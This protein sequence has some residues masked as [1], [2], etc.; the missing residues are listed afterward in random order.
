MTPADG[1]S[2]A[3]NA[4]GAWKKP[5]TAMPAPETSTDRSHDGIRRLVIDIPKIGQ[6]AVLMGNTGPARTAPDYFPTLVANDVLGGGYSARLNEEIR[7]KRG[8]SYG[9]SSRI[10]SRKNAAPIIAAAQTRNDAVPQVVK[11]M[12]GEMAKL[13]AVAH[14]GREMD[15]RKATLI[16]SFGRSVE[17]T[18]GLAGQLSELA[19]FN[20]PL[21][22]LRTYTSDI[23]AV[24]PEAAEAAA[25]AH[26]SPDAA[27]LVVVGDSKVFGKDLAK[28]YPKLETIEI[29]KLNLDS[30]T[31]K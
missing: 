5:D 26:Y 31:L 30:A 2:L 1:F 14:P 25:K 9:A 4:L 18:A 29:S 6:A 8:L 13:G 27:S 24:T 3:E 20:L 7:I 16:G 19:Q 28:A 17:T 10:A 12:S 21:D 22:K 15:A 11:L 23:S